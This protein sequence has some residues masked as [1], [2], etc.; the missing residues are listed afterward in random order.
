MQ[1]VRSIKRQIAIVTA[2][3]LAA[4][5]LASA[6]AAND[7]ELSVIGKWRFTKAL[8]SADITP[9]DDKEAQRL[10]GR[11]FT[12]SKKTVKLGNVD[13]CLPPAF[14]AKIVE[15]RIYVRNWAHASAENLGLPN[16]VTVVDLGC[17][18]AFIKNPKRIVVFWKGWFFDARR[19]R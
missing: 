7:Q 19:V 11:V 17:T 12:I 8:D 1:S 14:E 16:P 2:I 15:P 18:N 5:P 4:W 13:D 3:V 10:V 9:L 6:R